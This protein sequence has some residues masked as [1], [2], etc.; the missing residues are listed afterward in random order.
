L[1][2]RKGKETMSRRTFFR[3]FAICG[4][5][6]VLLVLLGLLSFSSTA[7]IWDG[8]WQ[9]KEYRITFL[10]RAGKPVKGVQLRVENES[11]S[12]FHHFPV[13]DYLPDNVP[14]SDAEG[15]LV[16]HHAPSDVRE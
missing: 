2:G 1:L 5:V 8:G 15:V 10:D 12:N 11:A 9:Q 3:W 7:M 4:T 13:A 16:F 6:G 14:E